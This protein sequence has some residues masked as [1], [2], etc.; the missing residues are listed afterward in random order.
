MKSPIHLSLEALTATV[1]RGDVP[2]F[3]LTIRNGGDAPEHI[4][5]LSA[6][7]RR[8]LQDTYYDLMVMQGGNPVDMPRMISDPGPP[9]E[10]DFLELKPGEKVTFEL[11]RFASGLGWLPPGKYQ[12]RVRFRQDPLAPLER[13]LFSPYAEFTVRE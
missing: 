10:Q 3:R 13:D 5:D 1:K 9:I 7:R 2:A 11:T 12:A 8:I 6:G 4:I